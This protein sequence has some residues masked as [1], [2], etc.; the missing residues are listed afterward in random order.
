[1]PP[2]ADEPSR[3][4]PAKSTE[5]VDKGCAEARSEDSEIERTSAPGDRTRAR[6]DVFPSRLAPTFPELLR[7][8]GRV[9]AVERA[10]DAK[11]EFRRLKLGRSMPHVAATVLRI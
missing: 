9:T 5:R 2:A 3:R 10:D 11:V 8:P 7:R 1:M 6:R 4:T